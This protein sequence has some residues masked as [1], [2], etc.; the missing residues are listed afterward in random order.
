MTLELTSADLSI[1]LQLLKEVTIAALPIG[2]L[3]LTGSD[4][5]LSPNL[6]AWSYLTQASETQF[7]TPSFNVGHTIEK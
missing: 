5:L 2:E 6:W 7:A 4:Y 1:T 3:R